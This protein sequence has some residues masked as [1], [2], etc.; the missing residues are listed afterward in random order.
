MI[1]ADFEN[2]LLFTLQQPGITTFGSAPNFAAVPSPAYGKDRLDFFINRWYL[3]FME[4]IAEIELVVDTGI[5]FST[6][7][8]FSYP[9]VVPPGTGAP[10]AKVLRVQYAP[11]GQ[12][13][14]YEY[15]QGTEFISWNEYQRLYTDQGYLQQAGS[16]TASIPA[17]C[18][19]NINRTQ[20]WFYPGSASAG[21]TVSITYAPLPAAGTGIAFMVNPNDKPIVPDDCCDVIIQ[22]ALSQLWVGAREYG[23]ALDARNEYI[24]GVKRIK[25]F[26]WQRGKGDIVS[27]PMPDY[28]M[29]MRSGL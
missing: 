1:L 14:T 25:E 4:D 23:Q 24:A 10:C 12:G 9:I 27:M 13:Y 21:D 29:N 8:T 22:G 20:V 18:A 6:A 16:N 26:Y 15:K 11:L 5:Q 2:T 28:E 19:V 17:V 7:N 3:R